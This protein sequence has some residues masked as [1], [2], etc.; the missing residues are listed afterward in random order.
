MS[1]CP[2][3]PLSE[4]EKKLLRD[5]REEQLRESYREAIVND[6]LRLYTTP[7]GSPWEN[8]VGGLLESM[9]KTL[10]IDRKRIFLSV[11]K[12]TIPIL[13]A[14]CNVGEKNDRVEKV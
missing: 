8:P 9:D 11:L 12:D 5:I 1:S 14:A 13:E 6:L 2:S 3:S 4:N 7:Q 10:D